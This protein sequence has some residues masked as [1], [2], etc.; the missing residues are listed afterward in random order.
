MSKESKPRD[1]F[2]IF[3][4]YMPGPM[5]GSVCDSEIAAHG[6]LES[7]KRTVAAHNADLLQI[8]GMREDLIDTLYVA[9]VVVLL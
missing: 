8:P 9:K 1:Q 7:I 3:S 4:E 2:A 6:L 5:P